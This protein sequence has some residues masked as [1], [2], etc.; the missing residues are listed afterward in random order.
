MNGFII[1]VGVALV[2]AL[3]AA[4]VG[5]HVVDWAE[6]R[7]AIEA[8]ASRALG[9][10]VAIRGDVGVRLLPSP[11]VRVTD[12]R[13]GGAADGPT[14]EADEVEFDVALTPLLRGELVIS[15][16]AMDAPT[17]RLRVSPS[18][19]LR[20]P[21]GEEP[22]LLSDYFDASQI[23]VERLAVTAGRL[24]V[25]D[26]RTGARAELTD[27]A[28]RGSA[29]SLLGP[30]SVA[31]NVSFGGT[32]QAIAISGGA[33]EDGVLPLSLRVSPPDGA[34]AL[35]FEGSLSV[36]SAVSAV[37]GAFRMSGDGPTPW[38]IA[39]DLALD[40]E[41]LQVGNATLTYG[42]AETPLQLA[43]TAAY[44]IA[45][46]GPV[47]I[48]LAARQLDLDR[49]DRGLRAD[50]PAKDT[51]APTAPRAPA[52]MVKRLA[53]HLAP[54][55]AG[56]ATLPLATLPVSLMVDIDMLLAGGAVARDV[57]ARAS[58]GPGGGIDIERA[59]ALLP[60]DATVEVAG[61]L[62]PGGYVG[63]V[64]VSATQPSILARW[65]TGGPYSGV[66]V[67]PILAEMDLEVSASGVAARRLTVRMAESAVTGRARYD[68]SGSGPPVVALALSA[69]LLDAADVLAAAAMFPDGAAL[70]EDADLSLDLAVDRIRI[71]AVEGDAL[72]VDASYRDGTLTVD[73][74]AAEDVGGLQIFASGAIADLAA[75]P[76]GSIEGTVSVDDGAALAAAVRELAPGGAVADGLSRVGPHLSPGRLRFRLAGGTSSAVPELAATIIGNLGG[77]DLSLSAVGAPFDPDWTRRRLDLALE[78]ENAEGRALVQQLGLPPGASGGDVPATLRLEAEGVPRQGV[79]TRFSAAGFGAATRYEGLVRYDGSAEVSGRLAFEADRLAPLADL[80]G[81][82]LPPLADV[83]LAADVASRAGGLELSDVA[84]TVQGVGVGATLEVARSRIT[85]TVEAD[86]VDLVGLSAV[87]LGEDAWTASAADEGWPNRAFARGALPAV[88][89]ELAVRAERLT[90]GPRALTDAA[91]DLS[92]QRERL[93]LDNIR[94]AAAGG[95]ITG[96]L[97]IARS[98]AEARVDG[99]VQL[100]AGALED[101]VWHRAGEA[102]ARGS[103]DL[104]ATFASSNYTVAGLMSEL[105]GSGA[106]LVREGAL[107]GLNPAPFD[108]ASTAPTSGEPLVAEP[109]DE[110]ASRRAFIEH[111]DAADLP[112]EALSA[113]LSI[114][115]GAVRLSEVALT[116]EP[117]LEIE[118]AAVDL[119]SRRLRA[120]L[121]LRT[122]ASEAEAAS[123]GLAFD[124]PLDDP[125]RTVDVSR[126]ATWIGLR[127]LEQQLEAVERENEALASEADARGTPSAETLRGL[128]ARRATD[129]DGAAPAT[130]Q[131]SADRS[132]SDDDRATD[133]VTPDAIGDLLDETG[134]GSDQALQDPVEALIRAGTAPSA[135][136]R[137]GT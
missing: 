47:R 124:G 58:S 16:L 21:Q 129:D 39:G 54:I 95:R 92:I 18:G 36:G 113:D 76:V 7:V 25:V 136:R 137:G 111:L 127:R 12:V 105:T 48:A 31:G 85:G 131:P 98:G 1:T 125:S 100:E 82:A 71:G 126:L 67:P 60:G 52:Q 83:D 63:T 55:A 17:L 107:K 90:V 45:G 121:S 120:D 108:V 3:T 110:A 115:N 78:A 15:E 87:A 117:P 41:A 134:A 114:A 33:I 37:A 22:P 38:A 27:V 99:E 130:G 44:D 106:L 51:P 9:A 13:V 72:N 86:A 10:P 62:S 49:L 4:L 35:A 77:T 24:I 79:G 96:A 68:R 103:L 57:S 70:V 93:A 65:W 11:R 28:M 29:T 14:L 97:S 19:A 135:V 23:A 59:E 122:V 34:V 61:R 133:G 94:A 81:V 88:P 104:T 80:V 123:I 50:A 30:F 46:D 128:D 26:G 116:P 75:D 32:Q 66:G 112:F 74:L 6:Y 40:T 118:N 53:A 64:R 109:A 2:L 8:Y 101:L 20:L 69:P 84:G 5:P 91:F 89:V 132:A 56:V 119:G 73:A 42:A 102:V 43:G